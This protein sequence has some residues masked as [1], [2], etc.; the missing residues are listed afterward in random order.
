MGCLVEEQVSLVQNV[1][2]P[3]SQGRRGG[4]DEIV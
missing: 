2:V 4:G 3:P 1:A